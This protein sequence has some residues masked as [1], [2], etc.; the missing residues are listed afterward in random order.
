MTS[1]EL[2]DLF[3]SVHEE[4]S[5]EVLRTGNVM[6]EFDQALDQ[7]GILAWMEGTFAECLVQALKRGISPIEATTVF[8]AAMLELGYAMGLRKAETQRLEEMF[9]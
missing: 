5:Q 6:S 9:K 1:R 4:V 8:A 2:R 3:A 7:S